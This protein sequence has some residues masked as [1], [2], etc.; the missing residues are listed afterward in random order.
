[1]PVVPLPDA[2]FGDTQV[3][4]RDWMESSRCVHLEHI[5]TLPP[6]VAHPLKLAMLKRFVTVAGILGPYG[7]LW[8]GSTMYVGGVFAT[9]CQY[10]LV[11]G[12]VAPAQAVV[13][14]FSQRGS[15]VPASGSNGSLD[16]GRC[17]GPHHWAGH[18]PLA[19]WIKLPRCIRYRYIRYPRSDPVRSLSCHTRIIIMT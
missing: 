3:V 12:R 5:L 11:R 13:R 14:W 19:G 9:R 8:S 15:Q 7:V 10:V 16:R 6:K 4:P 2:P 17:G 18:E 1:M